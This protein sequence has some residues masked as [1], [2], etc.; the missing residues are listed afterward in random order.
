[1]LATLNEK[2]RIFG[3][4]DET[5]GAATNAELAK[6]RAQAMQ[7]RLASQDFA[8]DRIVLDKPA[9]AEGSGKHEQA[10]RVE[11]SVE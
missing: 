10:R 9:V 5:G 8:A 1:V 11:V 3:F 6:Q 7:M 4:Q 2:A